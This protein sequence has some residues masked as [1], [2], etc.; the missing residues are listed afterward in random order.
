VQLPPGL[1]ETAGALTPAQV[2]PELV[3]G[4]ADGLGLADGAVGPMATVNTLLNVAPPALRE[5]LLAGFLSL[6]QHPAWPAPAP[7]PGAGVS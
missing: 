5:A 6:L 1:L 2:T 7:S 4:L 3:A